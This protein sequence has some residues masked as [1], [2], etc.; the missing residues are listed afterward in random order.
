MIDFLLWYLFI[1]LLGWLSFPIAHRLLSGLPG[2]G[3]SL[4][5]ALGLLLWGFFF[6]FLTSV[7]LLQNDLAGQLLALV[8]LILLS[9][10]FRG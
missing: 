2:K 8:I 9:C 7:G 4:S 3:Y 1:S 5:K 6:W 10:L